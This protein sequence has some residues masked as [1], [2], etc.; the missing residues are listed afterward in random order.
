[1]DQKIVKKQNYLEFIKAE[2]K[3]ALS[4]IEDKIADIQS[5]AELRIRIL[6]LEL[7]QKNLYYDT[8]L[9]ELES[10]LKA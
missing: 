6:K 4:K 2:R 10:E 8:K 5:R 3:V 7:D 1:M 9:S